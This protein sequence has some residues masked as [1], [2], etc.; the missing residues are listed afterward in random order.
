MVR[1][2]NEDMCAHAFKLRKSMALKGQGFILDLDSKDHRQC[3][4]K[5]AGLRFNYVDL[6]EE[7]RSADHGDRS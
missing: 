2:L 5:M 3:E 6:P 4:K 7:E 1:K